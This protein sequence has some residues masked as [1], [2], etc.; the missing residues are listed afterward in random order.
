MGLD[1]SVWRPEPSR[2]PS[3]QWGAGAGGS[4]AHTRHS[5]PT[6]CRSCSPGQGQGGLDT[7][8]VAAA[9]GEGQGPVAAPQDD[10]GTGCL[11]TSRL[12]KPSP[13]SWGLPASGRPSGPPSGLWAMTAEPLPPEG[14][15]LPSFG[16]QA[17]VLQGEPR[18]TEEGA[19]PEALSASRDRMGRGRRRPR[20]RVAGWHRCE[21]PGPSEPGAHRAVGGTGAWNRAPGHRGD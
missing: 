12:W 7:P 4:R 10:G 6:A 11:A 15:Q 14:T 21:Q 1:L 8:L 18:E 2:R 3:W 17:S 9:R 13:G 16:G 19:G 5:D 20:V